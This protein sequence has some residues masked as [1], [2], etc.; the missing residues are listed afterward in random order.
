MPSSVACSF[1]SRYVRSDEIGRLEL[2]KHIASVIYPCSRV[3]DYGVAIQCIAVYLRAYF[4]D[5]I[6]CVG[7]EVCRNGDEE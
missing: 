1:W 5:L 3:S 2:A 7:S 4:D 6:R